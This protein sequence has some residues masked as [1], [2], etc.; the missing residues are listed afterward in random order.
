MLMVGIEKRGVMNWIE[1]NLTCFWKWFIDDKTLTRFIRDT[2]IVIV[3]KS[4][5]LTSS[6][7][8]KNDISVHFLC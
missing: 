6:Q 5:L 2:A 8:K 7:K 3:F 1:H 4:V